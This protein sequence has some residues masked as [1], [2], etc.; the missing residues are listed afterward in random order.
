MNDAKILASGA[1]YARLGL[2]ISNGVID[3]VDGHFT[4]NEMQEILKN[5]TLIRNC[6]SKIVSELLA[7]PIDP[8]AD[9]KKKIERRTTTYKS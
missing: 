2:T 9:Q 4:V 8:W 3:A 1:Q 6:T 7:V 5:E